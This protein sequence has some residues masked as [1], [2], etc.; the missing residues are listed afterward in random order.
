MPR[1]RGENGHHINY[2]HI[3]DWLVRKPGAF[4]NYRYRQELFPTHR[5]RTVY[6]YLSHQSPQKASRE[7]LSILHL[8][9]T[10]NQTAVDEALGQLLNQAQE[11]TAKAVKTL[12]DS[13]QELLSPKDVVIAEIDIRS[14]DRLLEVSL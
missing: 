4:E 8:A 7:Y 5:F 3:V 6:D 12:V 1:L 10:E 13:G 2:R 9:A 14:Y 11:I